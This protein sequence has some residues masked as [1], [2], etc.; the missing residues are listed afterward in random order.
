MRTKLLASS[1]ILGVGACSGDDDVSP[2]QQYVFEGEFTS[3]SEDFENLGGR[4][5]ALTSGAVTTVS[6]DIA[7]LEPGTEISWTFREG[8]CDNP[9]EVV[10][11]PGQLPP[12]EADDLGRVVTGEQEP[13][14]GQD[15]PDVPTPNPQLGVQLNPNTRYLIRLFEGTSP[16]GSP[17]ACADLGEGEDPSSSAEPLP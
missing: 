4:V 13:P 12:L 8:V 7:G 17:I 6:F 14:P 15:E 10:V 2:P 11:D 1:L 5:L 16:D 3:L 9:G